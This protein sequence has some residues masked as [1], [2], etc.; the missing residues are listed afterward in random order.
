MWTIIVVGTETGLLVLV[1]RVGSVVVAWVPC[2]T[3]GLVSGVFGWVSCAATRVGSSVV[4]AVGVI[5][6]SPRW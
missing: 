6:W 5:R 4:W 1:G 3:V 2:V